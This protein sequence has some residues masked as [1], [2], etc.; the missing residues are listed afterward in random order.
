VSRR[1]NRLSAVSGGATKGS[2][3]VKKS[4]TRVWLS[5]FLVF[6]ALGAAWALIMPYN[7]S[8]DENDHVIR[9]A[10]VVR[11][12]IFVKPAYGLDDGGYPSVPESLV[13]PNVNCQRVSV[14]VPSGNCLG[15]PSTSTASVP[16]HSR[17]ARY[18]PLYYAAVGLP[19]LP[20]PN[21]TGVILARLINAALCAALL[22]SA[23]VTVWTERR[24]RL[25][26]LSVLLAVSPTLKMGSPWWSTMRPS[27]LTKISPL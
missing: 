3:P 21:M 15:K 2:E 9:A 20:F 5:G 12:E 19:L 4:E 7:S 13:P 10:G 6:L 17:A 27:S 22:A 16:E 11:G 8:Y 26:L 1:V 24:R 18:N 25:L 14:N 23:L